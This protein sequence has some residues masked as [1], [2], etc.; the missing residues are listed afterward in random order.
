MM[1][2]LLRTRD[3]LDAILERFLRWWSSAR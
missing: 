3:R 1:R 2:F